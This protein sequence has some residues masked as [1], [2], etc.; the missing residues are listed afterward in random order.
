MKEDITLEIEIAKGVTAAVISDKLSIKGPKGI[1]ERIFKHPR[2]TISA[3][4]SKIRLV[5]VAATKR[6]KTAI[7]SFESHIKNMVKGVQEPHIYKVRVCSGHF[8]MAVSISGTEFTIKN[9]LGEA[10]PRKVSLMSGSEVK[11]DGNDITISSPNKEIAGQNAAK[12]E[13]LT[14]I[15]NRDRRIFQDGCYITQKAGRD[16]I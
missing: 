2:I 7:Y 11:V 16:V 5:S 12:I 9:F 1:V 4:A 6:E 14:R 13:L 15:T 8:P 3:D 10:V